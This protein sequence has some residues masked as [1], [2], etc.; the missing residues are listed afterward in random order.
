[1]LALRPHHLL[2][3]TRFCVVRSLCSIPNRSVAEADPVDVNIIQ[4]CEYK[5]VKLYGSLFWYVVYMYFVFSAHVIWI[6]FACG[7]HMIQK[8]FSTSMK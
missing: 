1:M 8:L 6:S 4:A 2:F 5:F 3:R 7:Q